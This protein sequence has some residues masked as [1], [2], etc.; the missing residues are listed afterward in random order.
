MPKVQEA[1]IIL[2][3]GFALSKRPHF[4]S[5]YVVRVPFLTGITVF[6]KDF[7]QKSLFINVRY[8]MQ[9]LKK[10]SLFWAFETTFAANFN[11]IQD[12]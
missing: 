8:Q 12:R 11:R 5:A 1:S 9:S 2:R 10:N 3:M 4:N 7:F 6:V